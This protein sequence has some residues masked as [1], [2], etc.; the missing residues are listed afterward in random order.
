MNPYSTAVSA[1]FLLFWGLLAFAF[2]GHRM[3]R[4]KLARDPAHAESGAGNVDAVVLSLLGLLIAFTFSNAYLRYEQRRQLIVSEANA[5]GTAL[6]RVDLLPAYARPELRGLFRDYCL[7]R[8]ESWRMLTDDQAA[9]QT[10]VKYTAIQQKIWASVI[11][12]TQDET[13]GDARKL[14]IPAV[15]DMIDISTTRLIVIQSHPPNMIFIL[16]GVLSLGAAW[17]TGYGMS[18]SEQLSKLHVM[19]F[20]LLACLALYVIV[21]IEYPRYGFV[22]LEMPHRLFSELAD[23]AQVK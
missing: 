17:L 7:A 8:L 4:R 13:H 18:R 10:V 5:I 20:S 23:Q 15:N 11:E 6:L 3:G 19:A 2:V 9:L 22:T 1:C 14:M 16:L 21:D 12:A